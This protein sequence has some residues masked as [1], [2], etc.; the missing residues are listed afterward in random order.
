MTSLRALEQDLR[1][2]LHEI[3]IRLHQLHPR[4]SADIAADVRRNDPCDSAR[5]SARWRPRR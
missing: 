2:R 5:R 1:Q 4:A 3:Q